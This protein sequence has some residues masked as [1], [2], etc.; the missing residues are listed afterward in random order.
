MFGFT[1]FT[2]K[3]KAHIYIYDSGEF[4]TFI[5]EKHKRRGGGGGGVIVIMHG[6][7][8]HI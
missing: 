7:K 6:K 5:I 2:K 4:H 3:L 1:T 8:N